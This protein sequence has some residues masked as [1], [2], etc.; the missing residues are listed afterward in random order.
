MKY[1][2]EKFILTFIWNQTLN[3]KQIKHNCKEIFHTN[4]ETHNYVIKNTINMIIEIL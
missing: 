2:K 4:F 3:I 1:K